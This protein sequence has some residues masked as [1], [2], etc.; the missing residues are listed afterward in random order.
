PPSAPAAAAPAPGPVYTPTA[1]SGQWIYTDTYGWVWTPY[2]QSYTYVTPAQDDAYE[3][4]YY[5]A[6]GWTWIHTPWVIGVGPYP[7]WGRLG[8][9]HFAWY[10]HPWFRPHRVYY[11]H[12]PYYGRPYRGYRRR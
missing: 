1:P 7:Y 5:P 2:D 6:Y 12:R 10:V 9:V 11:Y 4:V 3:Y 8:P